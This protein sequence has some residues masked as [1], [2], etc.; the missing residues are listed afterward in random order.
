MYSTGTD[1]QQRYVN[2]SK[3]K[4]TRK[5]VINNNLTTNKC[6]YGLLCHTVHQDTLDGRRDNTNCQCNSV[7]PN[8]IFVIPKF[9]S[10]QL[11]PMY[12]TF[13]YHNHS[14]AMPSLLL[15]IPRLPPPFYQRKGDDNKGGDDNRG[16]FWTNDSH[17]FFVP[18]GDD[19][20]GRASIKEQVPT[21]ND[22]LVCSFIWATVFTLHTTTT[23]TTT[24]LHNNDIQKA[25]RTF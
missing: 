15:L 22:K 9:D 24:M 7:A 18:N 20:E 16:A 5:T 14:T 12:H 13:P 8:S 23:I 2:T 17:I 10:A 21:S 11:L 1:H 4:V 19:N 3:F 6:C 25:N